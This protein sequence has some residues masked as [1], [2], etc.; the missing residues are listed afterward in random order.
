MAGPMR[1]RA[2]SGHSAEVFLLLG[3][4][5]FGVG[6]GSPDVSPSLR[7]AGPNQHYGQLSLGRFVKR[8]NQRRQFVFFHVLNFVYEQRDATFVGPGRFPARLQQVLKVRLQV[9]VV[10]EARFR[11]EIQPDFDVL[12]LHLQRTHE[13]R[14]CSEC[15]MRHVPRR[16]AV[17]QSQQR[18]SQLRHEKRG[19]RPILGRFYPRRA[20]ADAL[21]VRQQA[22]QQNRLP[23]AAKPDHHSATAG[24]AY[25]GALQCDPNLLPQFVTAG[26]FRRLNTRPWHVGVAYRIH[27]YKIY[28]VYPSLQGEHKL[29]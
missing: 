25:P 11:L 6:L 26:Q 21:G 2:Q 3:R 12:L 15:P 13:S 27:N 20:D 24:P 9:T 17:R 23:Y 22:V 18:L 16:L 29:P 5:P 10:S 7:Q 1:P 19:Q 14:Q 28:G 4:Q 8:G